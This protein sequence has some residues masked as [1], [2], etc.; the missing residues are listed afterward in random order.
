MSFWSNF[1]QFQNFGSPFIDNL[2][3][4]PNEQTLDK[5]LE[6]DDILQETKSQNEKLINFLSKPENLKKLV[7]YICEEAQFPSDQPPDLK[8]Q[9]KYP[10]V[11]SEILSIE[12]RSIYDNILEYADEANSNNNS[13]LEAIFSYFAKEEPLNTTLSSY[14]SKLASQLLKYNP[15]KILGYMKEKKEIIGNILKHLGNANVMEF[16]VKIITISTDPNGNNG[17]GGGQFVIDESILKWLNDSEIIPTLI[18]KYSPSNSIT[19]HENVCQVLVDIIMVLNSATTT[20]VSPI[21]EKL[22]SEPIMNQLF[23]YMFDNSGATTSSVIEFG[24]KVLIG[25]LERHILAAYDTDTTVENLPVF[26]KTLCGH[27][28]ILLNKLMEVKSPKKVL[29]SDPI[30]EISAVG[31]ERLKI[32]EFFAV[33]SQSNYHSINSLLVSKG[34][35][36]ACVKM[37]F[38]YPW[39]N[40]LHS[41][42]EWLIQGIL[43]RDMENLKIHILKDCKLI[44]L[45]I[46]ASRLSAEDYK[47]P[48][49][50]KRGYMGHVTSICIAILSNAGTSA[51]ID[52]YLNE[53]KE[54]STFV[55]ETLQPTLEIEGRDFLGRNST[56][57][58]Q[59]VLELE[60]GSEYNEN[61]ELQ[62]E[63]ESQNTSIEEQFDQLEKELTSDMQGVTQENA[64]STSTEEKTPQAEPE[65]QPEAVSTPTEN[66]TPEEGSNAPTQDAQ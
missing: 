41:T 8:R 66:K 15:P 22:E 14:V 28:D 38:D 65:P 62:N 18:S 27:L 17:F 19:V 12:V 6:D 31:S 42:V 55:K 25:L 53:H 32:V 64:N 36:A 35:F 59:P 46:E 23:S 58:E 47:K 56:T 48:K 49:G 43:A 10:F 4:S 52:T 20:T 33:L 2:L 37:F 40:F 61:D 1:F 34:I 3:E 9:F 7:S 39:N 51:S 50:A 30:G 16:L 44:D 5:L 60:G 29:L 26:L 63:E 24:L 11:A 57:E 21:I 45:I 54:W 13:I